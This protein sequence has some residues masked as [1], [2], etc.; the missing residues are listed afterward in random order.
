M[1]EIIL[2]NKTEYLLTDNE[3]KEAM[4][5]WARKELYFANALRQLLMALFSSM[6]ELQMKN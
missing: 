6:P 4:F 3:F 5:C 1:K 2:S